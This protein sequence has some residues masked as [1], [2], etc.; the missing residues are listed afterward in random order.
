MSLTTAAPIFPGFAPGQSFAQPGTPVRGPKWNYKSSDQWQN[1]N[2]RSVNGLSRTV[3]YWPNRIQSFEWN[4]GYLYDDPSG[5]Q[6]NMGAHS[7][8]YAQPIPATDLM[9]LR[10]FYNGMHG[11]GDQFLFQPPDSVVGGNATINAVVGV[12]GFWTLFFTTSPGFLLGLYAFLSGLTTAT[13]LNGQ[14]LEILAM[15]PNSITVYFAHSDLPKAAES[16]TAKVGQ[17]IAAADANNN[18]ELR[19]QVGSYPSLPLAGTPYSFTQVTESV[20][21]VES[22]SVHVFAAGVATGFS[23]LPADTVSPYPGL[24]LSFSGPPTPPIIAQ[25][26]YYI[27]CKFSEDTQQFENFMTM[28]WIASTVKFEQQRI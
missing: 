12:G 21:V 3:K 18:S 13:W 28:L 23:L 16:G 4:Y 9:I 15:S 8:F 1:F 5:V 19:H 2:Q 10:S 27:P 14:T 25:Y 22:T 6:S 11:G 17:L 7:S 20:Q 26:N 24:V